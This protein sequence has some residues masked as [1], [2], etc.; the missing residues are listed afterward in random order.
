MFANMIPNHDHWPDFWF[1]AVG[2]VGRI[3]VLTVLVALGL[4]LLFQRV[5]VWARRRARRKRLAESWRLPVLLEWE[6]SLND[7]RQLLVMSSQGEG[8]TSLASHLAGSLA[9]SGRCTLLIDEALRAYPVVSPNETEAHDRPYPLLL[10]PNRIWIDLPGRCGVNRPSCEGSA[11]SSRLIV[12]PSAPPRAPQA[13]VARHPLIP[14][15]RRDRLL[16]TDSAEALD[17]P[18]A[19]LPRIADPTRGRSPQGLF[20]HSYAVLGS[21]PLTGTSRLSETTGIFSNDHG[22]RGVQSA[23]SGTVLRRVGLP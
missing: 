5:A 10:G 11:G 14:P 1:G 18:I 15:R 20:P 7:M 4:F 6:S 21:E 8:K 22:T 19:L 13:R 12:L 17:V 16:T 3:T 2:S 9:R 23:T